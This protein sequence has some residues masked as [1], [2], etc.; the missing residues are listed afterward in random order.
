MD[1]EFFIDYLPFSFTFRHTYL[2]TCRHLTWSTSVYFL[3][4]P[5][6]LQS[7]L[8]SPF[9]PLPRFHRIHHI[10]TFSIQCPSLILYFFPI[11][12]QLLQTFNIKSPLSLIPRSDTF[13]LPLNLIFP[14]FLLL[15]FPPACSIRLMLSLFFPLSS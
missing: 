7:S 6:T 14:S 13:L 12:T 10:F 15:F 2:R 3:P 5:L 1:P 4:Y 9:C 11:P 8:I